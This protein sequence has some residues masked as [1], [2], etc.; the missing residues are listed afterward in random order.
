MGERGDKVLSVKSLPNIGDHSL[1]HI[2]E[3]LHVHERHLEVQ[4]GELR[5]TVLTGILITEA[6]GDLIVAIHTGDHQHLL[7]ELRGLGKRVECSGVYPGGDNIIPGALG[8]GFSENRCLDLEETIL[9]QVLPGEMD[10]FGPE[11]HGL[12]HLGPSEV[13]VSVPHPDILI[14]KDS[15]FLVTELEGRC[16]RFVEKLCV[17]YENLYLSSG[18]PAVLRSLNPLLDDS[19][20]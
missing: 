15:L 9:I 19:I 14:G 4:L 20:D 1:H 17:G 6:P 3:V 13:E 5:L 10:E 2:L 8:S 7:E 12:N 16:D 18:I 11:L